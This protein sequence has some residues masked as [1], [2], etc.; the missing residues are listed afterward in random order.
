MRY[1]L[2]ATVLCFAC[3][4]GF[5][6]SIER[7]SIDNG[8][9]V[10][11]GGELQLLHAIGEVSVQEYTS[12][13]ISISEGFVIPVN[14]LSVGIQDAGNTVNNWTV[15]PNPATDQVSLNNGQV[16]DFELYDL[17]GNMVLR[18]ENTSNFSVLELKKGTYIVKIITRE[19]E[20][21][22]MLVV[23]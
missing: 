23:E 7:Q 1:L 10:A 2:L 12:G 9:A 13:N 8:G 15:Y 18:K 22:Q 19:N 21:Q 14:S 6:Q 11:S 4:I 3:H 5:T 17:V 16:G 20:Y